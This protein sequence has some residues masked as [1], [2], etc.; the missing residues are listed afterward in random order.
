MQKSKK[1]DLDNDPITRLIV[2]MTAPVMLAGLLTTSYGFV[3]MIFASRLGGVQVAS[4]AFVSPLFFMLNAIVRG[5]ARGGVSVIA[6]LIGQQDHKRAAAYATQLRILVIVIALFFSITGVIVAAPLLRLLQTSGSL[7]EQSLIYTRIM[8]FALPANAIIALY[9]T[10]FMSQGKMQIA[11]QISLLG[12]ISNIIMNS[13][14]IYVLHLGI[15]GL[16]YAT[17][18][19]TFI[20][21]VFIVGLYHR[22][23][24]DFE[25]GWRTSAA[26]SGIAIAIHLLKVGLPLS[27]SGAS[28]QFGFLLI[29][30]LIAPMGYQV[31]AAFAIGNRINSLMFMPTSRMGQGVVPLIAHNWGAGAMD[32][33]R[34]TVK[35]GLQFALFCG[36]LGGIFIYVVRQPLADFLTNDDTII[37]SHALNYIGLVG[38]TVIPWAVFQM[39][40]SLFEGFQKT[41]F[42]FWIN[43]F[44]LWGVRIPGV[45]LVSH[46]LP[47]LAEYG[48]WYTMFISNI[49]TLIVALIFFAILIPPLLNN[50][51]TL[52]PARP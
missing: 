43:V 35:F 7:F 47:S 22:G 11:T 42:A 32:R 1:L 9:M 31:V 19:T 36:I 49:L 39:L 15:D 25:I 33:V 13:I 29:N 45:L 28:T 50:S 30:I 48:V 16:A 27:F 2:R 8:C 6:K 5:I 46:F 41:G 51:P 18:V 3:D 26:F 44:R 24:H 52:K 23:N 10:L 37:L 4:V 20:Q 21:C 17:L 34:E 38:W 14:S 40:Q 12:V